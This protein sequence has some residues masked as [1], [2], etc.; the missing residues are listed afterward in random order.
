[1]F[2]RIYLEGTSFTVKTDCASLLNLATIFR[3]E[4]SFFQ[5]RLAA[6]A[7]FQFKVVHVSGKS[8]DIQMAD[9]LSRHPKT[10]S[11]VERGTQTEATG[12]FAGSE[13]VKC[14]QIRGVRNGQESMGHETDSYT[15]SGEENDSANN[16]N[17]NFDTE[18]GEE[19]EGLDPVLKEGIVWVLRAEMDKLDQPVSL[20][21]IK[22]EYKH[23]KILSEVIN[24]LETANPPATIEYRKNPLNC[25]IFDNILTYFCGKMGFYTENG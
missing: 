14:N 1:M 23:D 22:E 15:E 25:V 16:N 12:N 10:V 7:A 9:Y 2:F 4:N 8:Q 18:S 21:E 5:R 11:K 6:L 3:N 13:V 24:W 17:D 20:N 19:M